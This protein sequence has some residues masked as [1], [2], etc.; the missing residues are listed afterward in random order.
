YIW[1]DLLPLLKSTDLNLINLEAALTT[2]ETTIPKVFHFKSDPQHVAALRAARIDVVNLAN[3][4]ILD[5]G[6]VG[7][8]ETLETLEKAGIHS[9]GAGRNLAQARRPVILDKELRVGI[10]GFTDNEPSWEATE[11]KP[12]TA[13]MPIDTV[14][15]I[16]NEIRALRESVDFL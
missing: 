13:Y 12:G 6:E 5:Y 9:V 11:T 14:E 7:L 3:N 10:L 8:L 4:H 16:A 2:S 1:G 15:P